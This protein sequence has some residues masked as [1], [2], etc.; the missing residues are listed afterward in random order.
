MKAAAIFRMSRQTSLIS[1]AREHRTLG[2]MIV[3]VA[4]V[5]MVEIAAAAEDVPVAVAVVD[6]GAVDADVAV[7]VEAD[8]GVAVRVVATVAAGGTDSVRRFR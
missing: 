4:T 1:I 2:V 6:G 8:A 3:L 7:E 5:R